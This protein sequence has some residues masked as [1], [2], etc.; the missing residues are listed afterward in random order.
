MNILLT[1]SGII[2]LGLGAV[3]VAVPV[4]PTTPFV[5]LAALCFSAGNKRLFEAL[6]RN[7]VFGQ[8]IENYREGQGI[9]PGLKL[10]SIAFLWAGLAVSMFFARAVPIYVILAAVGV[11]VTVHLLLIRTRK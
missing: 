1:V 4:M 2:F 10:A 8:Y 3:G 9:T 7:R 11:A 5:L 6:R